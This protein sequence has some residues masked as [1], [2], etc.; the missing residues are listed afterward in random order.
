[1]VV[2]AKES[3]H[4]S[5][6][7]IYIY[8]ERVLSEFCDRCNFSSILHSCP[9]RSQVHQM[10]HALVTSTAPTSVISPRLLSTR[11]DKTSEVTCQDF[12][13]K[14]RGQEP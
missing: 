5:S 2:V 3:I 6:L 12:F 14:A 8:I 13:G 4:L 11:P 10:D 9:R 7:D 1:M